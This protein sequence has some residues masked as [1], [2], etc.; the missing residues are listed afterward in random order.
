M[1]ALRLLVTRPEPDAT[2]TAA[3]LRAHGLE[4]MTAPLMS[5]QPAAHEAIDAATGFAGVLATSANALRALPAFEAAALCGLPLV[6]VGPRTAEAAREAGFDTVDSA[7]GEAGDLAARAAMRFAGAKLPLLYLAGEDRARDLAAMLEAH[8]IAVQMA[9][10][11]RMVAAQRFTATV[12][13]ALAAGGID[14]VLHYSR[15]TAQAYCNSATAGGIVPA[16]LAPVHY[17]LSPTIASVLRDV[18]AAAV[19]TAARP[20]EESLFG[21]IIR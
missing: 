5:M 1:N 17:C 11:Y 21:L 4:A 16:A 10:V 14:G 18:G 2:R 19:R 15:R 20:N 12:H 8:G 13:A 9:V 3:A 6:A 7:D